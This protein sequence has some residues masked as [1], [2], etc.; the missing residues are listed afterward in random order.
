MASEKKKNKLKN[1][2]LCN[3]GLKAKNKLK[4]LYFYTSSLRQVLKKETKESEFD[5]D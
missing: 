3:A 5:Q 1:A 2:F 4:G